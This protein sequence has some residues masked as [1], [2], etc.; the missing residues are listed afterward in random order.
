M[1][2]SLSNAV[3]WCPDPIGPVHAMARGVCRLGA[4]YH[5]TYS[6]GNQI[7]GKPDLRN[8]CRL[9]DGWLC[10]GL[11][12]AGRVLYGY[13]CTTFAVSVEG[14]AESAVLLEQREFPLFVQGKTPQ[15]SLSLS[16]CLRLHIKYG[17]RSLS[18]GTTRFHS[19]SIPSEPQSPK[20]QACL[21]ARVSLQVQ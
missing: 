18:T 7:R 9:H 19:G 12:S 15:C 5:R 16:S 1:G 21:Q 8:C 10:G 11:L 14:Q 2:Q 17:S 6:A 13:R 3:W 4:G 20:P